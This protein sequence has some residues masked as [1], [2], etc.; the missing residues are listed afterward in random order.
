LMWANLEYKLIEG[1]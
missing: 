1:N